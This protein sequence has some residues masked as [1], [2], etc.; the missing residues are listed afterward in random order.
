MTGSYRL[1]DASRD[2]ATQLGVAPDVI[3]SVITLDVTFEADRLTI[4]PAAQPAFPVEAAGP[5]TFLAIE[6]GVTV[7]VDLPAEGP[8]AGLTL[9]Q[10]GLKLSY[11]RQ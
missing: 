1:T 6:I 3:E 5:T 11:Q 2:Q 9:T 8:A 4:K 7:E 10:G